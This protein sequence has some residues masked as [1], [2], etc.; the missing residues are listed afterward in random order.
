MDDGGLVRFANPAAEVLLDRPAK[1]LVGTLFG[2]PL[3]ADE[4]VENPQDA[5]TTLAMV[6]AES[7]ADE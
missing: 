4:Q 3:V 6:L 7:R 1:E 2:C 5:E